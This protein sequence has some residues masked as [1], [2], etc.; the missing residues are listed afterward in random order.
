MAGHVREIQYPT[1]LAN[2]VMVHKSNGKWR[3]CTDFTNLNKACPKDSYP[4][5]NIDCLVDGAS[6]YE[7]LSF[8]DA[9]S[10]YNQIRMHSADENKTAFIADQANFCYRVMS[11]NLKN[12]GRLINE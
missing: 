10:G 7:L 9:Y 3:M 5:P 4:L 11:F 8:M 6:G 1:W 2:V 12:A